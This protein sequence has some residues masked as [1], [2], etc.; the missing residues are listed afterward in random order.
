LATSNLRQEAARRGIA[1]ER[2]VFARPL[3]LAEHLARER[4]AGLFLDTLP[5]NAHTS[6]SD[7]LWAGVP[8][9][10]RM[11]ESFAGRV[12]ASLLRALSLPESDLAE[13]IT[14][15]PTAYE[16]LAIE[17]ALNPARLRDLR[18][19]LARN[20]LTT[21]LFDTAAFTRHIESAYTAMITRY[22]ANLPPTHIHI[23]R[24]PHLPALANK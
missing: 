19:R 17:L 11:G 1:P 7:A 3:P 13:L 20:R 23:P 22:H 9:L 14:T 15:T 4:L 5:Y 18:E 6:A 21:P 8:V 12:A 16:A 2:L 10:T 24:S